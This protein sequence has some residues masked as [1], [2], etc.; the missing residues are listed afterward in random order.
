MF[1]VR[2]SSWYHPRVS[3]RYSLRGRR[4]GRR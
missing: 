3:D 1:I 4:Y 2:L